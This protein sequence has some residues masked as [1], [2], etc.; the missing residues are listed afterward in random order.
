[1]NLGSIF[2]GCRFR[3][4]FGC[5]GSDFSVLGQ[6]ESILALFESFWSFWRILKVLR[7]PPPQKEEKYRLAEAFW[8]IFGRPHYPKNGK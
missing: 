4:N 1:M 5:S 2:S 6:F 8:R 7:R 3:L